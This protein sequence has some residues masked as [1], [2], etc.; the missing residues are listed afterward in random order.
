MTSSL[1]TRSLH[2]VGR[3]GALALMPYAITKTYW[4]CGGRA[5]V[6]QGWDMVAEFRKNGA[7]NA[8]IWLEE[9]GIDF[10]AVLAALGA[11][12][13]LALSRGWGARLPRPLLLVPAWLGAA[14][15]VPYGVLTGV[16]A[17]TE[18]AG[19]GPSLNPWI[20]IA[21]VL[22]FCGVGSALAACA[23]TYQRETSRRSC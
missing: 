3:T 16:L 6:P 21:G 10:T 18:D 15:F 17:L 22:A 13:V 2:W 4:A 7:P 23:W 5:G 19:K 12:V 14:F 8:L 20:V 11:L 1:R 9:H